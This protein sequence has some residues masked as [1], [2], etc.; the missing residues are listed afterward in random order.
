M[1][2]E[3]IGWIAPRV[4]SEIVAPVGP[5]FDLDVIAE[6]ARV[7]ENADFDPARLFSEFHVAR[8]M[9]YQPYTVWSR[10]Q[11][12]GDLVNIDEEGNRFTA[13]N[14][15]QEGALKVWMQGGSTTL[16][17]WVAWRPDHSKPPGSALE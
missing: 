4:A 8:A 1:P 3:I 13:H 10:R 14:S 5:P 12:K 2:V 15:T 17:D 6:T 11:F 7:H 16:G 9:A